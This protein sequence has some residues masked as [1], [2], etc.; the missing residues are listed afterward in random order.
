ME[1]TNFTEKTA[2]F[3]SSVATSVG[4]G[5]TLHLTERFR[6]T[7][8]DTLLYEFT[9]DDSTTFTRPFTAALPMK[10]GEAVFEYACH[11]GNLGMEGI[12]AGHRAEEQTATESGVTVR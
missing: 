8:D 7:S 12:L 3:N 5:T 2:S 1:T 9:I 6:R 11:E 4:N 10:R